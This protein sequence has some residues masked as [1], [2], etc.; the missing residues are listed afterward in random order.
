MNS[1]KIKVRRLG[2]QIAFAMDCKRKRLE[3]I[4]MCRIPVSYSSS[5]QV[6]YSLVQ[7]QLIDRKVRSAN[8]H[9]K[10]TFS[11]IKKHVSSDK[12]TNDMIIAA[13][14]N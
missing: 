12:D 6:Y 2:N 3:I 10:E 4:S 14:Y 13:N 5:D 11:K 9:R 7:C 8:E 1:N